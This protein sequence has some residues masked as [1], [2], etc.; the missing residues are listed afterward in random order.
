MDAFLDA[1]GSPFE[2]RAV[3]RTDGVGGFFAPPIYLI[4]QYVEFAREASPFAS[5]WNS[6]P[7]PP[8]TSEINVPRLAVASATG[9]QLDGN[10]VPGRDI[11]DT[12]V[13]APV[14]TIAGIADASMQWL[15]QGGGSGGSALTRC[16]S[17][18]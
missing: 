9:P 8:G 14:K 4:D 10:P 7:L 6:L 5:L 2:R 11:S 13:T 16:C 1:G 15:E 12:L 3:S 17:L 18:T